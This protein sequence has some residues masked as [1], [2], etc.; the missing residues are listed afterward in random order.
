MNIAYVVAKYLP[1]NLT[2]SEI[3]IQHIAEELT[4]KG[5]KAIILTSTNTDSTK[6]KPLKKVEVINGLTIHR[7]K[8]LNYTRIPLVNKIR[9]MPQD[10]RAEHID[11]GFISDTLYT[12]Y[13]NPF[14]PLW[15]P[16]LY[17]HIIESHYDLIHITPFPS[18]Y[19]WI[20]AKAAK[21]AHV[22]VV[23]TPAFHFDLPFLFNKHLPRLLRDINAVFALT[24]IEKEKIV[25]LGVNPGKIYVLPHGI[26]IDEWKD[27]DGNRFRKKHN[28]DDK[29]IVLFAGSKSYDKGVIHLMQALDIIQHHNKNIILVTI[30]R[31]TKEL[32]LERAR[33]KNLKIIDLSYVSEEEKRDAFDSCNVFA[34]PSRADAFGIVYLEA[35][36][37]GK[38]VIGARIGAIQEVI[39]DSIDGY[40]VDFG[41]VEDLTK[42][43]LLLFESP[44]LCE[45]L[46]ANGKERVIRNHT[47]DIL[48]QK[49]ASIYATILKEPNPS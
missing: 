41:D 15:S 25:E 2:G 47:W 13:T 9:V 26:K 38:P 40:L 28:L 17:Q 12:L 29:F 1:A 10:A 20:A 22:P 48:S 5:N 18:T 23:C 4:R 19:M 35:W 8:I 30:G 42:K 24:N 39:R 33:L 37:C 16:A 21:K 6:H 14:A 45:Q 43:I 49:I 31:D 11:S 44:D 32:L 27:R 46:G 7:F 3:Y 36:I 34:M